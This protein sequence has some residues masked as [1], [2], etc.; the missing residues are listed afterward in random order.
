MTTQ[1]VFFYLYAAIAVAGA[2]G[3]VAARQLVHAVVSMFATLFAIA[4]LFLVIGSEFLAAM[5]LFV[6]GGAI[7]VLVLFVLMLTQQGSKEQAD[8]AR[9][10]KPTVRWM[11]VAASVALFVSVVFTLGR[12]TWPE[13]A[14][15]S[16]TTASLATV[17]FSR[18]VLPFEVAG[19]ILT[20]ALIGAIVLA[21]EDDAPELS[22]DAPLTAGAAQPVTA[23]PAVELDSAGDVA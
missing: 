15:T 2:V 5:Q 3:L 16:L 14:T 11:G 13:A 7:T 8:S 1:A 19:L 17:L 10:T 21:R 22:T 23:T 12:T 4:A 18:Y 6:Y 20:V 9:P